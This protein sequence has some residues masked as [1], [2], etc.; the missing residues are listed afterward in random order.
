MSRESCIKLI[1][2]GNRNLS[3]SNDDANKNVFF[4]PVGLFAI[5]DILKKNRC[6]AEIIHSDL[7]VYKDLEMVL[8]FEELDIVGFDCHWVNQ[9]YSVIETAK[10]I[11]ELKPSVFI[12]IGGYTASFYSMEIMQNYPQIDA[13]IRGDGEVP[14]VQLCSALAK[15]EQYLNSVQNLTW[16]NA[17]G[18]VIENEFSYIGSPVNMEELDYAPIELL[19]NWEL[20]RDFSKY[21]THFKPLGSVP[22][23]MLA[24]G[25]GCK[26]SC[27]YCGGSCQAQKKINNRKD[28]GV[29]SAESVMET[30]KK[31]YSLG[32]ECFYSGYEFAD[33]DE[34]YTLLLRKI[35]QEN[36]NIDFVHGSYSLPS[37]HIIDALEECARN[38]VIEI[39]PETFDEVLRKNNKDGRLFYNNAELEECLDYISTKKNIKVQLYFGYF[40]PFDTEKSVMDTIEYILKLLKKYPGIL[41]IEYSNFSTDP[42]SMIYLNPKTY[43]VEICVE[44]FSDYIEFIKKKYITEK[45]METD[46][47]I[48]FPKNMSEAERE[49][50]SQRIKFL[51]FI[52]SNFR[53]SMYYILQHTGRNEWVKEVICRY[54]EAVDC[55]SFSLHKAMEIIISALNNENMAYMGALDSVIDEYEE[56]KKHVGLFES[57]PSLWYETNTVEFRNSNL[58]D[59]AQSELAIG[60]VLNRDEEL[61]I[62]FDI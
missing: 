60:K 50:L 45:S 44:S 14:A 1:H 24:I 51:N 53:R 54:E 6:N 22:M 49:V 21:W 3:D 29:R 36:I 25:R 10:R 37:K 16:R 34:W 46:M 39:S 42:A 20:Y 59:T 43:N 58:Y 19:R 57:G 31:A 61:V 41:E 11:K 48:F 56:R 55:G 17:E 40:L 9:S 23:F 12:F 33:S 35:K 38:V 52:Y 18:Q 27:T 62:E 13:V 5:A 26:Y 4:M 15:G 8:D 2:C 47:K 30:I 7:E 28:V 32:F